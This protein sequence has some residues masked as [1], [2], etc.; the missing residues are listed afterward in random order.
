MLVLYPFI[1]FLLMT[2]VL[3]NMQLPNH[4]K[5]WLSRVSVWSVAAAMAVAKFTLG[6]SALFSMAAFFVVGIILTLFTSLGA[7]ARHD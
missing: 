1:A 5:L 7:M 3:K 4:T 6:L 2:F